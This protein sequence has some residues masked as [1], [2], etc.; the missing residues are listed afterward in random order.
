MHKTTTDLIV[1]NG[2]RLTKGQLYLRLYHGR[3][4]PD[5]EMDGWGFEGP[6]FGPLSTVVMT[7]LSTIRIHGLAPSEEV[8]L[9]TTR[10][11]I[12]WQ[13]SY[14]GDFE[15]FIATANQYASGGEQ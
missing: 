7:Y 11:M 10:D 1:P 9:E 15:I 3:K 8:W 12:R 14:F 6:V 13:G 2:R 4:N 5:Q